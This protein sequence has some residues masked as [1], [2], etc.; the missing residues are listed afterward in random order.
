MG[1]GTPGKNSKLYLGGT[2]TAMVDEACTEV[3][4]TDFQVTDSARRVLDPD[5]SVGVVVKVNG[6]TVSPDTY[7]V[8]YYFGIITFDTSQTGSAV[9]VTANYIPRH[10]LALAHAVDPQ[11]SHGEAE[12]VCFGN[13]GT[14]RIV[15][16]SDLEASISTYDAGLTVLDGGTLTLTAA[17]FGQSPKLF[18]YDPGDPSGEVYR[19]WVRLFEQSHSSPVDGAVDHE[20]TARLDQQFAA[21]PF[22]VGTP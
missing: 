21:D 4:G 9:T 18:E 5:P 19:A 13:A 10:M 11:F 6:A 8:N 16:I 1:Q 17:L 2:S 15:T 7:E 12:T 22:G 20:I 14:S 3:S